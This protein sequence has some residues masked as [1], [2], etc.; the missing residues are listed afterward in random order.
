MNL[1]RSDICNYRQMS[2][3]AFLVLLLMV[4]TFSAYA[5]DMQSHRGGRGLLP[6]NTLAAFENAIRMGTTTLELDLAITADGIPVISH[7][8]ALNPALTRDATGHWLSEQGPLIKTLTLA[9]VQSFDVGR[10]NPAHW[11]A[12]EFPMQRARD[13]QRIPT[14]ASLFKLANDLGAKDVHFDIETKINPHRPDDTLSPQAFVESLLGVVREAG[15][16]KRVMVQSFDWRTLEFLHKLA[17]E[18]RTMYLTVESVD[19]NTVKDSAWT[20]G[21]KIENFHGSVP[22]MIRTSAGTSEGVIWAPHYKYL[23]PD[24]VEV[25]HTLGMQVIPWTVND[26]FRME[27][28]IDWKVDGIISDYPDRLRQAMASKAIAL[29]SWNPE[30]QMLHV[31]QMRWV[32]ADG[33]PVALKG[34]NLGNWLLPEFWMMGYPEN[35]DVNDQCSLEVVLDRRFG[36]ATRERLIKLHRDNWMT[37]RDWDLIPQFGLNLVRVPFIWSLI[38]DEKSPRHLRADAWHYLDSAIEQ[39]ERR[40]LY[41]VLDLHGAVGSQGTEHHSGCAG[42][43]QYWSNR[44]FQERTRWLWREIAARYKNRASVAAYDLL[45][46]PWGASAEELAS[47]IQTLYADIRAIDSNHVILLPDHPKGIA[48]YG[49]PSDHGMQNVAFEI[50]P[51]PGFFGWAQPSMEVHRDWLRCLPKGGGVCEWQARIA[52]L[53]TALY[54]G[55]FQPWADLEPGLSGQITRVTFDRYAELGWASS[56]WAYKKLSRTGG[57]ASVNWGLVTNAKSAPVPILNFKRASLTAIENL[58][59]SFGKMPYQINAPVMQWMNS[60]T[61]PTPF[62]ITS[63]RAAGAPTRP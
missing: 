19:F 23:T 28:L 34:V 7:D 29:P 26:N 39:A 9:E 54:V 35:T 57:H 16:S 20:A 4:S 8:A 18:I 41:V 52:N 58:F 10:L 45:N 1:T 42:R 14:L 60:A 6:E 27:Q 17:P 25:A 15:M 48:A 21:H 49:N 5:F 62:D 46:E 36:F 51:Y 47:V 30:L 61:P 22:N 55:E 11:Y 31:D 44:D 59:Q 33:K 37:D 2:H 38:E 50:H 13:G 24:L 3:T 43:N 12:R 53:N 40:G 32:R 63:P 56:A